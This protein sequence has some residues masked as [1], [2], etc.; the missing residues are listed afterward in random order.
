MKTG[1]S[2]PRHLCAIVG[3]LVLL[4]FAQARAAAVYRPIEPAAGPVDTVTLTGHD[5]T[6]EQLVSVARG[7]AP[8]AVSPDAK[9]HQE[10]AHGLLLEAAAEGMAITGLNRDGDTVI[11]DGDP[12]LPVVAAMLQQKALAAFQKTVG[13]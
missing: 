2:R 7:G 9:R 11:F 5:L 8:V 1:D 12:A 13:K 4:G 10:D 3:V 6:V